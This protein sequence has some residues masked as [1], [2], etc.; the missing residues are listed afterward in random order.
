MIRE[1]NQRGKCEVKSAANQA[2]VRVR[3]ASL[4]RYLLLAKGVNRLGNSLMRLLGL[5]NLGLKLIVG[6]VAL[7]CLTGLPYRLIGLWN[8]RHRSWTSVF[9]CYA[10]SRNFINSYALPGIEG[11][12]RWRPSPIGVMRQNG[13]WG[14]VMASPMTEE[15][16]LD[17]ANA[18]AFGMLQYR[19][20]RTARILGVEV[21]NVAGILPAVLK[22]STEMEVNDTRETVV[23]A[24]VSAVACMR[25]TY[26]EEGVNDVIVLG[27]AGRIGSGVV[28]ALRQQGWICHIVD[29]AHGPAAFPNHLSHKPVLLLDIA[30]KG[31]IADYIDGMW[32]Q[33]IVLNE[34]FPCPSRHLVK[35]MAE[36]GVR[37]FHLAGVAGKITPPLPHGYEN[38][39][40]C[41][42]ARPIQGA[43]D[44]RIIPVG[45]DRV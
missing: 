15:D 18:K 35:R 8:R 41:C 13:E 45:Q 7:A 37:V 11:F 26:L 12:F 17:P 42:A 2:D 30:R 32:P 10:G 5:R 21:I 6:L 40:P 24:V 33:I 4:V 25:R 19:L 36:R 9:F 23:Q 34:V 20:A 27:G 3:I 14:L 16:F 43:Y 29:V 28:T 22:Q 1:L 38:A 39:I 44:V 31:A